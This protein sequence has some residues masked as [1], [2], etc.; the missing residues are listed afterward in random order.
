[1]TRTRTWRACED[2]EDSK[3]RPELTDDPHHLQPP[4]PLLSGTVRRHQGPLEVGT[5]DSGKLTE[6]IRAGPS[7]MVQP[8]TKFLGERKSV[9]LDSCLLSNHV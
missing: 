4:I 3:D 1:M 9:I 6:E 8:S 5:Q 2:C 7:Q